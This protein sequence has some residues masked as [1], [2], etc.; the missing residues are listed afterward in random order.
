MEINQD[1]SDLF[2]A[3]NAQGAEF[4]VVGAHALAAHGH[5]RATKDIDVWVRADSANAPKVFAALVV[6]GAPMDSLTEE[7]FSSPGLVFQIGVPPLRIDILT[8][9]DGL[10]FEDAWKN[11][12]PTH[13]GEQPC[14]VISREDLIINKRASG[15]TQDLA[16][17][18]K[19]ESPEE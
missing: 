2:A 6:F 19:L 16:D 14:S 8:E 3:L 15:R 12:V 5:V 4:L 9:V 10:S 1:F 18:E 11:R 7:D 13:F 17:I